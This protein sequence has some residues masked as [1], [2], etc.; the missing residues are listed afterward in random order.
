MINKKSSCISFLA[1]IKLIESIHKSVIRCR[2][3]AAKLRNWLVVWL[4]MVLVVL[5]AIS[6][7]AP[8][9][10][11][12]WTAVSHKAANDKMTIAVIPKTPEQTAF[13]DTRSGA[14]EAAKELGVEVLWKETMKPDTYGQVEVMEEMIGKRVD[15]I[16]I[17]V[18]DPNALKGVINKAVEAGIKV[19]TFDSD[20]PDSKRLFYTGTEN[21]RLGRQVGEALAKLAA[22]REELQMAILTGIPG[23]FQTEQRIK[24]FKDGA[25]GAR[26]KYL[27]VQACDEDLHKAVTILEQYTRANPDLDAWFVAGPWPFLTPTETMPILKEFTGRGGIVLSAES[28]HST[29]RYVK[30]GVVQVEVGQD[31]MLMGELG[32]KHLVKAIHG[33]KVESFIDTG[34]IYVDKYNVDARM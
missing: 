21:Y 20:A 19:A 12:R 24:G 1:Y 30:E 8:K 32:L 27:P 22:G 15:G 17:S 5:L 18:I 6:R 33:E 31:F 23:T 10:S 26:I 7:M 4:T 13:R 28:Y 16:L 14:E 29:F 34:T 11:N 9:E 25:A 2:K 3:E